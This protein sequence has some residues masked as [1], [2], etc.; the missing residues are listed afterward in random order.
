[1][2]FLNRCVTTINEI[3]C[4]SLSINDWNNTMFARKDHKFIQTRF[5]TFH[6]HLSGGHE[7]LKLNR[8]E[9]SILQMTFCPNFIKCLQLCNITELTLSQTF[10]IKITVSCQPTN[11]NFNYFSPSNGYHF[12]NRWNQCNSLWIYLMNTMWKD[13]K[14]ESNELNFKWK[15]SIIPHW[16]QNVRRRTKRNSSE[17]KKST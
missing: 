2:T 10:P 15:A 12:L 14:L 13:G 1:M 5:P 6:F 9:M 16:N 4:L 11:H 3:L 8:M 7:S 17:C